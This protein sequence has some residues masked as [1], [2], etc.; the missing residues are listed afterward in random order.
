M[1]RSRFGNT[2]GKSTLGNV[3]VDIMALNK[4]P[5]R[6]QKVLADIYQDLVAKCPIEVGQRVS[7]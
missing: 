1:D 6:Y 5:S 3:S 4:A 7:P 2:F